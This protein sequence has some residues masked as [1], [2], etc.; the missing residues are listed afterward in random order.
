M[1]EL[2]MQASSCINTALAAPDATA[3]QLSDL[4]SQVRSTV[5]LRH[6]QEVARQVSR[7][8]RRLTVLGQHTCKQKQLCTAVYCV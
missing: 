7:P 4:M 3:G 5:G 2:L 1:N 8:S 6:K